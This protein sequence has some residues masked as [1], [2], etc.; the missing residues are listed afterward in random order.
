MSIRFSTTTS[1]PESEAVR[2]SEVES[3]RGSTYS[4]VDPGSRYSF[5]P[6]DRH[7]N[8]LRLLQLLPGQGADAIK[9]T[10]YLVSRNDRPLYSA[11]SYAWENHSFVAPITVN[12]QEWFVTENLYLAL[13][14]LR[15][16][17]SPLTLWVDAICIDQ[18]NEEEKSWHVQQMRDTFRE[19]EQ[20][21]VWLGPHAAGTDD[22]IRMLERIADVASALG[23]PESFWSDEISATVVA[24]YAKAAQ[25]ALQGSEQSMNNDQDKSKASSTPLEGLFQDIVTRNQDGLHFLEPA[26]SNIFSRPWWRRTWVSLTF[27]HPHAVCQSMTNT[28]IISNRWCKSWQFLPTFTWS[29]VPHGFCSQA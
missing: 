8:E 23:P 7:K 26:T 1:D 18:K 4:V 13:L 24:S 21:I 2:I 25:T 11:L 28:N 27:V 9:C 3:W 20:V 19:A 14:N 29:A 16:E 22:A 12:D 15:N 5:L 10:L 6:L 17:R